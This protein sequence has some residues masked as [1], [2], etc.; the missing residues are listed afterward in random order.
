MKRAALILLVCVLLAACQQ[1]R[2]LAVVATPAVTLT[3]PTPSPTAAPTEVPPT[4]TPA[5]TATPQLAFT[6]EAVDLSAPL[7]LALS[8]RAC[9]QSIEAPPSQVF[10]PALG[11]QAIIAG[12]Q[13]QSGDFSFGAWIFC[14]E[15]QPGPDPDLW[16]PYTHLRGLALYLV[17]AYEGTAQVDEIECYHGFEP[18]IHPDRGWSASCGAYGGLGIGLQ[19]PAERLEQLTAAETP[20]RYVF[21]AAL[22]DGQPQGMALSFTLR[23]AND[24]FMLTQVQTVPLSPVELAAPLPTLNPMPPPPD[25][26]PAFPLAEIE[27]LLDQLRA[28]LN[29]RDFAAV[30]AVMSEDFDFQIVPL[31]G[32]SRGPEAALQALEFGQILSAHPQIFR[33][34][35][36]TRFQR[37]FPGEGKPAIYSE[38]TGGWGLSGQDQGYLS[39]VLEE[40]GQLR[41]SRLLLY[42]DSYTPLPW[43]ESALAPAGLIYQKDNQYFQ[44]AADGTSRLLFG[45]E[46]PV[47]FSPDGAWAVSGAAGQNELVVRAFSPEDQREIALDGYLMWGVAEAQWL[48][49]QTV[50]L[51]L[52]DTQEEAQEGRGHLALLDVE[53]GAQEDLP[54]AVRMDDQPSVT[55]DGGILYNAA[56]GDLMEWH[57]GQAQPFPLP[58]LT[59]DGSA[60]RTVT[61]PVLSPNRAALAGIAAIQ[62][63]AETLPAYVLIDLH[64]QTAQV[65]QTFHPIP[66]GTRIPQTL[67][68]SLDSRWLAIHSQDYDPIQNGVWLISPGWQQPI[69][70]GTASS[71]P[72]WLDANTLILSYAH[73]GATRLQQVSLPAKTRRWLNLPA[74]ESQPEGVGGCRRCWR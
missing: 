42:D 70:L 34:P 48:N 4:S 33:S 38:E 6:P 20:L 10:D 12:G 67:A 25:D 3:T 55:A 29:A 31:D 46:P 2:T 41:W 36:Y 30:R 53:S 74:G 9:A 19:L 68:W 27:Q 61:S 51:A 49:P 52:A 66:G 69:F 65:V 26:N 18:D 54:I 59:L 57:A 71:H 28:D 58:P 8:S 13:V 14:S 21:K 62:Q 15:M 5:L 24:G 40:D 43:L 73:E 47:S 39:V 56:N 22:P 1:T 37:N 11:P 23:R 64:N 7:I 16:N 63:G 17:W 72:V 35:D 45:Q 44:V 32:E 50:L 60:L